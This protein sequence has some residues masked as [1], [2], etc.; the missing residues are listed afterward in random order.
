MD[1]PWDANFAPAEPAAAAP[2][3]KSVNPWE[4]NFTTPEQD[5]EARAAKFRPE[6]AKAIAG[7]SAL[8]TMVPMGGDIPVFG[9]LVQRGIAKY[10]STGTEDQGKYGSTPEERY[11]N[12]LAENKAYET[13]RNVQNPNLSW[14]PSIAGGIASA[15]AVPLALAALPAAPAGAAGAAGVGGTLA[16][17]R[18]ASAAH[19]VVS[20]IGSGIGWGAAST[21]AETL[22]GESAEDYALRIGKGAAIGAP[23]GLAGYGV[24]KAIVGAG[25]GVAN[26]SSLLFNPEQHAIGKIAAAEAAAPTAAKGLSSAEAAALR[27]AGAPVVATDIRGVTPAVQKAANRLPENENI[28]KINDSLLARTQESSVKFQSMIDDAHAVKVGNPAAVIDPVASRA[29]ADAEARLVNKPAYDAAYAA[30]TAQ[31]IWNPNLENLINTKHGQS[32]IDW[33]V[34]NSN[35]H[36]YDTKS[37][38]IRNP[39]VKNPKTGLYE[40]SAGAPPPSLQF[41]DWVKRGL[42]G[43]TSVARNKGDNDSARV[44]ANNARS[45]T[46]DLKTTVPEYG[47]ALQGAQRYI[48]EDN[49]FDAGM[50]FF[51]LADASKKTDPMVLGKQLDFF[52]NPN[53]QKQYTTG[54]KAGFNEG[55]LSFLKSN[56]EQAAK[57]FAKNDAATMNNLQS[58][59]DPQVFKAVQTA[60]QVQRISALAKTIVPPAEPSRLKGVLQ[61]G[62]G[63]TVLVGIY[64]HIP[65][66]IAHMSNPA[67]LIGTGV[68]GGAGLATRSAY[69]G[70]QNRN[71][72]IL[73]EMATSNDPAILRKVQEAAASNANVRTALHELEQGM[74]RYLAAKG[75]T[76]STPPEAPN[77][78]I[79]RKSGG[80]VG[81]AHLVSR[82][83]K[84]AEHA[85]KSSNKATEPLLNASDDHVV[86][87]LDVAQRAI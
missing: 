80:K 72:R 7:Q 9:P 31:S 61:G 75:T 54:E 20:A 47:T 3:D 59:M 17:L 86:K 34:T 42:N 78:R 82:L 69:N 13:E 28:A 84:L 19:P 22:P 45:L 11:R 37:I 62:I 79:Q 60:S 24:S 44:I 81:H 76:Y 36:A 32:A 83:M 63:A 29:A 6:A 65:E 33:A 56:P 14:V 46:D 64:N 43:A 58:V 74:A 23:L 10:K 15:A 16:A 52:K 35:A 55:L 49:A 8:R 77:S 85:K 66:I 57:V 25:K 26:A 41:W 12:I 1:N 27:D 39:F 71:A 4:Q 38:P 53:P 30:P 18:A 48:K 40:L 67:S 87:A 50:K 2:S 70:I 68:L 51:T 73:L 21:A 5:M